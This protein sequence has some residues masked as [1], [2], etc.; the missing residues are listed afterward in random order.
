MARSKYIYL[1]MFGDT[2]LSAHTVKKEAL[3]WITRCG[4]DKSDLTFLR[5]PD[6]VSEG[7]IVNELNGKRCK[8]TDRIRLECV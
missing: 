7:E 3:Q 8:R 5:M 4:W 6:G 1:V 2:L